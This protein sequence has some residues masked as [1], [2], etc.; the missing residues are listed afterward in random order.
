MATINY[1]L[2]INNSTGSDTAASGIG[3]ST[4]VTG[5]GAYY[6]GTG[7]DIDLS[8]DSPDLSGV[9]VGDLIW[10][11]GQ[12]QL[13][14]ITAVSIISST[15]TVE[16]IWGVL[17]SF[18]FES[19]AIGGKRAF[20][21]STAGRAILSRTNIRYQDSTTQGAVYEIEYT[22][23]DYTHSSAL[24]IGQNVYLQGSGS[25]RPTL[26]SNG[27]G[28]FVTWGSL[29]NGSNGNGT[30]FAYLRFYPAYNHSGS[31]VY[32]QYC[33]N[34]IFESCVFGDL[35]GS[36]SMGRAYYSSDTTANSSF[37]NCKFMDLNSDGNI[38]CVGSSTLT[39]VNNCVFCRE[40]NGADSCLKVNSSSAS[41]VATNSFFYGYYRGIDIGLADRVVIAN[42][43]FDDGTDHIWFDD[44]PLNGVVTNCIFHDSS[45]NAIDGNLNVY[46]PLV[47]N[48]FYG[49][50]NDIHSSYHQG[51]R[52]NHPTLTLTSDPFSSGAFQ[53]KALAD[54]TDGNAVADLNTDDAESSSEF[55]YSYPFRWMESDASGG[56]GGSN[57]FVIED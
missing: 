46:T 37:N 48:V 28:N 10:L 12:Q 15:V 9:Q 23:T 2:R 57:V 47:Q 35:T 3:P 5:S 54:T 50:A 56:G 14:V 42:C 8:Y 41:L 7:T 6:S 34:V 21:D 33:N 53:Q 43:I 20:G 4:A 29:T 26:S 24:E 18:S 16:D 1:P 13:H 11:N 25:Q 45:S 32:N 31:Y 36:Y 44:L 22:G 27:V 49:N 40:S 17:S 30:V 19:W 38:L 52:A 39:T 51:A 55:C